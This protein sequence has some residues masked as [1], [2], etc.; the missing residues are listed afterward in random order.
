MVE[1]VPLFAPLPG[2]GNRPLTNLIVWL[3]RAESGFS[4]SLDNL[5]GECMARPFGEGLPC[6]MDPGLAIGVRQ[7][8]LTCADPAIGFFAGPSSAPKFCVSTREYTLRGR[9]R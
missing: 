7:P 6:D 1:M 3:R 4:P 8:P 9:N 5:G 2:A